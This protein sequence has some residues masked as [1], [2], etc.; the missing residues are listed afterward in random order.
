MDKKTRVV[1]L[2]TNK[3]TEI[4]KMHDYYLQLDKD[5]G[6]GYAKEYTQGQH[7][8][9]L[10]D[11]TLKND[12]WILSDTSIAPIHLDGV[13]NTVEMLDLIQWKKIIATTD[14]LLELTTRELNGFSGHIP[15]PQPPQ[16]FLEL[17]VTEYNK[18]N[19]IKEVLVEYESHTDNMPENEDDIVLPWRAYIDYRLKIENN[20]I[21]I[22]IIENVVANKIREF[23]D[24][25][26]KGYYVHKKDL[27]TVLDTTE[28]WIT[29]NL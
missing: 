3:K 28:E 15:L 13:I 6:N 4:F 10:S 1:I 22:K 16:S 24:H 2:P 23:A 25:V 27:E 20:I 5:N 19:V 11:E 18:G 29:K 9:F 26:Y 21:I 8:Y 17:Y 7:L 12:D 14:S